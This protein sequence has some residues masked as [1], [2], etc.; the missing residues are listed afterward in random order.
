MS[1]YQTSNPLARTSP[2]RSVPM[3]RTVASVFGPSPRFAAETMLAS[4]IGGVA[5]MTDGYREACSALGRANAAPLLFR[6]T[7]KAGAMRSINVMRAR[8]RAARRKLVEAQ[9]R[10]AALAPGDDDTTPWLA[11]QAR[12]AVITHAAHIA[13]T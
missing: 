8:L 9:V 4:A 13:T 2:L 10:M 6:R 3:F 12:V 5:A 1:S 11:T 7:R